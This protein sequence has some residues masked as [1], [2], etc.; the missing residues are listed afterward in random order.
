MTAML[1]WTHQ[2]SKDLDEYAQLHFIAPLRR[3]PVLWEVFAQDRR[4]APR[5]QPKPLPPGLRGERMPSHC[6]ECHKPLRSRRT[7][8]TEAPEGFVAHYGRGHCDSCYGKKWGKS[9]GKN[10]TA[11]ARARREG[12]P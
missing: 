2:D 8:K 4:E 5:D 12:Q 10:R 3:D 7:P 11:R 1:E 6:K 9:G